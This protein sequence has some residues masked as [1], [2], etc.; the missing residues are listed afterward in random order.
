MDVYVDFT[1]HVGAVVCLAA[2]HGDVKVQE[3]DV[4]LPALLRLQ[5]RFEHG[6]QTG[7]FI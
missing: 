7:K 3:G 5:S 2:R 4:D 6:L 1:R